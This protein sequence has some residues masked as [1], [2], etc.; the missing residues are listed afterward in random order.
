M[1]KRLILLSLLS[2]CSIGESGMIPSTGSVN[3]LLIVTNDKNQWEGPLGDTI[4]AFF[5]AEQVGLSQPEP[6]FDLVNIAD[7]YLNEIFKK[8]HNIFIADINSDSIQTTSG[9]NKDLWSEPQRVIK[10]TAPDLQSFYKEFGLKKETFMRL[11][12]ELERERTL[13]INKMATDIQLSE[14]VGKKFGIKPPLPEGFYLAKETPD[15]M[16]LRHKVTKVKQDLELGILIYSMNYHDTIVFDPR[17]IIRW[18]NTITLENIPGPSP[19]SFMKVADENIPPVFD[20]ITDFPG[21]YAVETRGLWEVENDF[22]GGPFINYT[23]V[24]KENNKVITI[25]GYIYNPNDVKKYYLRELES[26]F[27]DLKFTS[28]Q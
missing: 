4:R 8:Y 21:G 11:F 13:H 1:V 5:G 16:W 15:F 17:H 3:E 26:I 22:M 7:E 19:T 9:T 28:L 6:V 14:I 12:I 20:T 27:F 25:D 18:R 2:S 23:F 10:I 24:D